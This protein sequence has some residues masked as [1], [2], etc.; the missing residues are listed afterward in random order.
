MH[1]V[2]AAVLTKEQ[3]ESIQRQ[4]ADLD[5]TPQIAGA[6]VQIIEAGRKVLLA[7]QPD[8]AADTNAAADY[9]LRRFKQVAFDAACHHSREVN[10]GRPRG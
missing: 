8:K 10:R 7:G 1:E 4:Q 3:I 5:L 6:A 2:V 9:L